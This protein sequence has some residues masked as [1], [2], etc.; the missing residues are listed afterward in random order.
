MCGA[1]GISQYGGFESF[2]QNLIEAH[3]DNKSIKYHI[4][5]KANGQGS[6]DVSKLEG[7]SEVVNGTF[8]Y[9]NAMCHLVEV[10]DYLGSAQAVI[11]DIKSLKLI[12]DH[13]K[14]NKVENPAVYILACRI[15]PFVHKY[16]NMIHNCGGKVFL[17]PDGHE[18]MRR[19]WSKGVRMYWKLS[20]KLM[21]KHADRIICDSKHIEDYI[22][23]DY[24]N[25]NPSTTYIS[26]GAHMTPSEIADDDEKI[27]NWYEAHNAKPGKYYLVVGRFVN[28]NNYDVI[29][30]EFMKST[31]CKKLV[32][33][34]TE[35]KPLMDQIEQETGYK[36]DERIIFANPVYDL[37]LL[38]KIRENAYAYI[39]GH[40]VGGT[41]PSL[42]E[43]LAST[44]LNLVLGVGFNKEVVED[45]AFCW[46]KDEDSLKEVINMSEKL[47]PE[48]AE[49]MGIKAKNRIK[50][51]YSWKLIADEYEKEFCKA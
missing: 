14:A 35:N 18:W 46:E 37:E 11:Y 16:V 38:K 25:Y 49:E 45:A 32:I 30:R 44:K 40:E 8:E 47:L 23:S 51:H 43:A 27:V 15:G 33:I 28:E 6:M 1:K 41:N 26:Y 50:D 22:K 17:N 3:K 7:A 21:V 10:P 48:E 2:V 29:I 12:C 31:S 34:T 13:I 36:S 5:C 19:K 9:C 20:E 24:C 4:M 42:L 39:H